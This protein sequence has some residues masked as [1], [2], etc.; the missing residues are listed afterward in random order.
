MKILAIQNRMGIGDMV[1]FLPF[2]DAIAKKYN[3]PIDILVKESSK[4]SQILKDNKNIGKI[5]ILDRDNNDKNKRHDGLI[6]F[7]ALISDLK[8]YD[9]DKVFIFNSSLRFYLI[10]KFAGIKKIYQYPL[11]KKKNQHIIQA[12]QNFIKKKL[13]LDVESNP[14]I[15]LKDSLIQNSKRQYSIN[16][17]QTNIVLGIGGSGPTKRI[18][19][20]KFLLFMHMVTEQYD[21]KF[22]LAT[23]DGKDEQIILNQIM[24]SE[25]K[26][27][28]VPLDQK[29]LKEI[30]PIIKNCQISICNDS[31][32]SHLSAALG[33][34]TI[35]LVSDTPL[36]YGNYSP[37]MHPIIPDGEDTVGHDTLGKDKINPE[38][39]FNK[40]KNI[41]N[42][43]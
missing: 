13:N 21:C 30:L 10:C 31:S 28:C 42:L 5:I 27:K 24:Q 38:K 32:F 33:I 7:F 29:N 37:R 23:G 11:F 18:P 14:L 9:F 8:K 20:E 40:L 4:A 36:L 2:I 35:V 43:N 19:A 26:E 39:I 22:F 15:E 1:I 17:N 25:F 12:A 34:P 3:C 16:D 41:L 6:G